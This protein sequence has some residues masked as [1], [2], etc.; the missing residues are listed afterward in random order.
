MPGL[1][2]AEN[3]SQLYPLLSQIIV[4][5]YF[6]IPV[7]IALLFASNFFPKIIISVIGF[8][9]GI[10]MVFPMISNIEYIRNI[11]GNS[12]NANIVFMIITGL[13]I[14]GV[15][16][17]LFKFLFFVGGLISGFFIGAWVYNLVYPAVESYIIQQ[18]PGYVAPS[19]LSFAIAGGFGVLI[20]VLA[21][22]SQEKAIAFISIISGSL[23]LSFFSSYWLIQFFPDVLGEIQMSQNLICQMQYTSVGIL[24][25]V[26]LIIFL[27]FL[28]FY[29]SRRFGKGRDY[30][31]F[32]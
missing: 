15:V 27:C 11:I 8:I 5:W 26:I 29:S 18:F 4:H 16:Y 31:V 9:I 7:A 6:S 25:F 12:S 10:G 13:V 17:A 20:G 19:W 32:S 2:A 24:I 30:K 14:A 3:I 28:G 1:E 23:I 22:I 21:L